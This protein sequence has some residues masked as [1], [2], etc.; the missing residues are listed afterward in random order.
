[1]SESCCGSYD[2]WFGL[3]HCFFSHEF[4][5]DNCRLHEKLRIGK[6]NED[7]R[8]KINAVFH[9]WPSHLNHE[10]MHYIHLQA[11]KK[12]SNPSFRNVQ[13]LP[14][15]N[16]ERFM[17]AYLTLL[18]EIK[19]K[20]KSLQ[21]DETTNVV[22]TADNI[23]LQ[24]TMTT[25]QQ[26]QNQQ[27]YKHNLEQH[28]TYNYQQ[29]QQQKQHQQQQI[30]NYQWQQQQQQYQQYQQYQRTHQQSSLNEYCCEK[31][32]EHRKS[33]RRGLPPHLWNCTRIIPY[34]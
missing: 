16:R 23:V 14:P 18:E 29:Q 27:Y 11:I 21:A 28:Q 12:G 30:Y 34:I 25:A 22:A 4:N 8:A 26:Q 24:T 7:D 10:L 31:Y 6:L 1:M 9:S 19:E 13:E 15:D 20:Y 17:S 33:K 5:T 32:V 3:S 2:I